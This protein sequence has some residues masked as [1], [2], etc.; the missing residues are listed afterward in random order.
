MYILTELGCALMCQVKEKEK[1][2]SFENAL[3]QE[4]ESTTRNKNDSK[5]C[6]YF[7]FKC[8]LSRICLV[9]LWGTL[10]PNF[11]V[12]EYDANENIFS[13]VIPTKEALSL[14][15]KVN[16]FATCNGSFENATEDIVIMVEGISICS[17]RQSSVMPFFINRDESV[18]IKA[19]FLVPI[20]RKSCYNVLEKM[21]KEKVHKNEQCYFDL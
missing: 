10:N 1:K 2:C 8:S 16:L 19:H 7:Q 17:K 6:N 11:L 3:V 18:L 20:L 9:A 12:H 15:E 21:W 14:L 4:S 5:D 13:F